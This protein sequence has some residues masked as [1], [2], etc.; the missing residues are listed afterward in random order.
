MNRRNLLSTSV[1]A[2]PAAA[3]LVGC[4]STETN[5]NAQAVFAQI[6]YL[7][8]LVKMMAAGIAIAVPQSAGIVAIVTPYLDQAGIAFQ[9][10]SATMTVVA[11][12]PIVQQVEGYAKQ[13]V[14]SVANV[15][16]GAA[17]GSKLAQ[18]GPAVAEAQGVLALIV[19]FATGVQQ[20][21]KAAMAPA[22]LSL[23]HK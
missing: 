18:F 9:G 23:L 1:L 20:M 7:L 8:P 10:L 15:V 17:P 21:P 5:A 3:V 22:N 14:D 12:Q 13:A 16:N 19:A 2:L 4:T 11:A 6:Q